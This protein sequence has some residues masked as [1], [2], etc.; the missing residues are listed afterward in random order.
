MVPGCGAWAGWARHY[1][2][3]RGLVQP[4][5]RKPLGQETTWPFSDGRLPCCCWFV[6]TLVGTRF[7]TFANIRFRHRLSSLREGLV[8]CRRTASSISGG[9]VGLISSV[10]NSDEFARCPTH[11][12]L[13]RN[14][15]EICPSP[16][17][18][19]VIRKPTASA[20]GR[21]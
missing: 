17:P 20:V 21:R 9:R 18:R 5:R 13:L 8:C 4:G 19:D 7:S 14:V 15:W 11:S 12:R 3:H 6:S 10:A 2:V 16:A 1:V